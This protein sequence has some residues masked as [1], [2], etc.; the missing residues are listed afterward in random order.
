MST[1]LEILLLVTALLVAL[2]AGLF[3]AFSCSVIPGLGRLTDREYLRAMQ[4]INRVILNPVFFASFLGSLVTLP[5]STWLWYR[6]CGPG[7]GFYLLLGATALYAAGVF[8]VTISRNVPLNNSLDRLETDSLPNE[9]LRG[10][11]AAFEV[12]WNRYHTIR[13]VANVAALVCVILAL[14]QPC[15]E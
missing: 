5:V 6:A 11:R 4:S 7:P 3:Y 14:L 8:G 15:Y 13:T 1:L 12:P 9:Q 10:S 2:A